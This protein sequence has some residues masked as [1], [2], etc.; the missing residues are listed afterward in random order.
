PVSPD[1]GGRQIEP[2]RRA[3]MGRVAADAGVAR[4]GGKKTVSELD[5][6]AFRPHQVEGVGDQLFATM[7]RLVEERKTGDD[8]GDALVDERGEGAPKV[9]GVA[10]DDGRRLETALQHPAEARIVFDEHEATPIEAALQK[11]S[12]DGPGARPELDNEAVADLA[13]GLSHGAG[14]RLPGRRHGARE[15]RRRHE[16]PEEMRPVPER[17]GPLVVTLNRHLRSANHGPPSVGQFRARL[18]LRARNPHQRPSK[19]SFIFEK[20]PALSGW[21]LFED[22]DANSI[23]SSRCR[24][25]RFCGVSTLSWTNRS[26]ASRERRIGMPLPRSLNCRPDCAPSGMLTFDSAPS[27]V[28]TVN[29]PPSAACTIEIGTRQ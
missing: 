26:P 16:G 5:E 4:D 2:D 29:S 23:K 11:R 3:A 8:G 9:V 14:E 1:A 20:K 17:G 6:N 13:D 25:V 7:R 12:G 18:T 19:N 21:V 15:A 10:L 24:R 27:S 22:S 28:R